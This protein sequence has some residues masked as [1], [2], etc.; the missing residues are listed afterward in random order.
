ML[1]KIKFYF[2][3]KTNIE[4]ITENVWCSLNKL[5]EPTSQR[6]DSISHAYQNQASLNI[7]SPFS[8]IK[9]SH[10]RQNH[11]NEE[12][13]FKARKKEKRPIWRC[14]EGENTKNE[15]ANQE[16]FLYAGP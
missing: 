7:G 4:H 10:Q 3:L 5:A 12:R 1:L 6:F 14:P 13:S 8:I 15:I 9:V 16:P 11:Q 2:Q